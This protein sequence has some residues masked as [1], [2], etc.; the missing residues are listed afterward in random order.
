[1]KILG[2]ASY[3]SKSGK[4]LSIE[5]ISTLPDEFNFKFLKVEGTISFDNLNCEHLKIEGEC[6]GE[7][8][9]A[10][11]ISI[12]GTINVKRVKAERSIEIEGTIKSVSIECD[13]IGI[14]S[15]SG[16]VEQIRCNNIKIYHTS[17]ENSILMSIFGSPKRRTASRVRVRSINAEKVDLQNCAAE[18]VKCKTANVRANCIIEK[19]IVEGDCEIATDSTV[20]EV[21]RG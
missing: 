12:E 7:T 2:S 21:V 1:M 17:G 13:D 16:K 8:I 9:S 11:E 4:K 18:I 3:I 20:S 15:Q 14:Y 5:G 19:L 6:S 10:K